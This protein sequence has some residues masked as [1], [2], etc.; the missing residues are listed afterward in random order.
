MRTISFLCSAISFSGNLRWFSGPVIHSLIV[1]FPSLVF[2]FR[3]LVVYSVLWS[4]TL[5]LWWSTL[6]LM[7]PT[8]IRIKSAYML[9]H[10]IIFDFQK[11]SF[12]PLIFQSF[13]PQPSKQ[14]NFSYHFV[15]IQI[16]C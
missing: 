15:T 7:Q 5:V 2:C 14:N 9:W 11:C 3:S 1:Y 16:D 6:I 8:L 12:N 13:N 10:N 4:F